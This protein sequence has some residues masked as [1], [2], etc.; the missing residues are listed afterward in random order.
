MK[1]KREILTHHSHRLVCE[2]GGDVEYTQMKTRTIPTMYEH[3]CIDCDKLE[4][5]DKKYPYTW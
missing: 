3:Q 1:I 2:C 5:C 4:M